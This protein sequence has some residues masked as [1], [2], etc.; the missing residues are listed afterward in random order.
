MTGSYFRGDAD[1]VLRPED[2]AK[3]TTITYSYYEQLEGYE[4]LKALGVNYQF[5]KGNYVNGLEGVLDPAQ[6][7]IIHIP[8]RGSSEAF[9][10]KNNEV[11]KI[12]DFLGRHVGRDTQGHDVPEV[13][14]PDAS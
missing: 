8:H 3:F 2:E 9:D 1:P 10:D 6:R 5:Y 7:T 11:G 12:M 4:H 14:Q 13:R